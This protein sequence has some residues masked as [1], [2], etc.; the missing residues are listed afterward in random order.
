MKKTPRAPKSAPEAR[1]LLNAVDWRTYEKFL[2]A[3]GERPLRLTYDQGN[4]EIMA[5]SWNHEWWKRRL[6]YFIMTLCAELDVDVQGGGSTTFRRKD[7]E[8]GIEPDE[9]YYIENEPRIRGI[10]RIDLSR[11]PPPDLAIEID[12]EST[13]L[14]RMSI[15]AALGVPELWRHDGERLFMY[16]L[17][18]EG[19]YQAVKKSRSFS[20][21]TADHVTR[22]LDET[23]EMSDSRLLRYTGRWVRDNIILGGGSRK[24]RRRD[25]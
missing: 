9:C 25:E 8:R 14:N 22:F 12:I 24:K 23:P 11:H 7:L 15:Y 2:D 13:S 3:V 10:K 20:I 18:P 6:D 17:N 5:P 4:L 16:D 19:L 1:I 21:V